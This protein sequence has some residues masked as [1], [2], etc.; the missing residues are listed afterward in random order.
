MILLSQYFN[1]KECGCHNIQQSLLSEG[2][3]IL[4][5]SLSHSDSVNIIL[6]HSFHS[7]VA[8]WSSCGLKLHMKIYIKN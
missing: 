1:N 7:L 8:I 2:G 6:N 3:N 4:I 5:W